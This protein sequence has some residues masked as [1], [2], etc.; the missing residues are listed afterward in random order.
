[1]SYRDKPFHQRFAELGDQAESIYEAAR[2][3]GKTVRF[4]FRR[5]KGISFKH[6]PNVLRHAP[7][8]YAE[9][10]YLVEVTGLG[11][12][13][14]LKSIKLEKYEA[15]KVWAKIAKLLG[16]E[17]AIFIWNSSKQEYVLLEW[18]QVIT[19]VTAARKRG[20]QKFEVDNVQ[21]FAIPWDDII[22]LGKAITW[23][24]E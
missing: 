3:L 12:D 11:K 21:Y 15:L 6:I 1:M 4:G 13:G 24:V 18:S 16:V 5:P 23:S 7:D 14:I 10:G 20:I 22:K 19:L 2:P 8:F 9:S 17:L